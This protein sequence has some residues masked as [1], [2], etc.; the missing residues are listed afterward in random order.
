MRAGA[1]HDRVALPDDADAS[2]GEDPADDWDRASGRGPIGG[3]LAP[4][5]PLWTRRPSQRLVTVVLGAIW[6][7]D[8]LLQLQPS[9][10]TTSFTTG[11][12]GGAAQGQPWWVY[13][14][15]THLAHDLAPHIAQWNVVFALVQLAIGA[16]LVANRAVRP[17]LAASVAWTLGV[18]WFGEGFGGIFSGNAS[19]VTGAPGAVLLY[20]LLALLV[21]P[22]RAPSGPGPARTV[23]AQGAIGA[24]G[25]RLVWAL[26]WVGSAILQVLPVNRSDASISSALRAGA[27]GEPHALAAVALVSARLVGSHG[28]AAAIAL[29]VVEVVVGLGVVTPRP[30]VALVAG[31]A[32]SLVFWVVGQQLGG[33]LT[34]S[35][36][37]PN[38]GPLFV[39]L[40]LTVWQGTPT[41]EH[42][43]ARGIERSASRRGVSAD[44][45]VGAAA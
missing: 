40:A 34:G 5:R 29:A 33:I 14:S 42:V 6:F 43:R 44:T 32:L 39:V 45:G 11:T 15:V 17:A 16:C 3:R 9:M 31:I 35:G 7:A 27:A 4:G 10:F 28:S 1:S 30:N 2:V 41:G 24:R 12:L 13:H 21:W 25:G 22:R 18:W 8:G 37:D 20:G 19:L 38:A 36:T 26:L 23:A